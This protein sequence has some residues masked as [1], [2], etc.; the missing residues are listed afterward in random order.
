M[1]V[2][3]AI[4]KTKRKTLSLCVNRLGAIIVRAPLTA[5]DEKIWAFVKEK[6]PWLEKQMRKREQ[7][8]VRLPMETLDGYEFLLLGESYKIKLYDGDF[9]RL[10]KEN[11]IL[12]APEK[13]T[14]VRLVAWLKENAR[15]ILTLQSQRYAAEMGLQ[16]QG[17]EISS[18]KTR[19]GTCSS[20]G[21]IRYTYRLL[22][23]PREVIDYVVVHELAHLKHMNHGKGFWSLVERYIPDYKKRRKWLKDRSALMEIF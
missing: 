21:K 10:D 7:A 4:V 2:P 3:S 22:F 18:A 15:R 19:W 9:I 20:A 23:A 14:K 16:F 13:K 8:G 11:K 17:I 12:F 6:Q 5:S 1:I